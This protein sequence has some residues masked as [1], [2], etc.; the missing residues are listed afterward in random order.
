[1]KKMTRA[2]AA[3]ASLL[4]L[5]CAWENNA[6]DDAVAVEDFSPLAKMGY[7][8]WPDD[9]NC[10]NLAGVGVIASACCGEG[11]TGSGDGDAANA[12]DNNNGAWWH[13]NWHNN[14]TG[15][16][17]DNSAYSGNG[18]YAQVKDYI[19]AAS[20]DSGVQNGVGGHWL[21]LD[22][23]AEGAQDISSIAYYPRSEDYRQIRGYEIWYSDDPIG[24]DTSG[25]TLAG[26][27][28]WSVGTR[29]FKFCRF[30]HRIS[31]R[32]IQI[33]QIYTAANEGY[34][35]ITNV[36]LETAQLD[37]GDFLGLDTSL[38]FEA[39]KRGLRLLP[40]IDKSTT[41][42][43]VLKAALDA[44]FELLTDEALRDKPPM[45][46]QEE[47]D[48]QTAALLSV[49]DTIDPPRKPPEVY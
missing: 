17:T 10:Y 12:I 47:V 14:T 33:R 3:F 35:C 11:H 32:Y 21:T 18:G 31:F 5:S 26:S 22:M 8:G 23:G 38:L 37:P 28:T 19:E 41:R 44:A 16:K 6:A 24:W 34:G 29:E 39:Y 48:S 46:A 1:M 40:G 42:Y 13:P 36:Y 15:H 9:D 45:N 27:G 2:L 43:E 30:E 20:T 4:V 25:A 49:L 7:A